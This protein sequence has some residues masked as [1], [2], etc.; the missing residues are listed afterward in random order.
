MKATIIKHYDHLYAVTQPVT[1][2]NI[3]IRPK[4]IV[5]T[6]SGSVVQAKPTGLPGLYAY[7][8]VDLG[9]IATTNPSLGLPLIKLD[10]T[11]EIPREVEIEPVRLFSHYSEDFVKTAVYKNSNIP[12]VNADGFVNITKAVYMNKL[13]EEQFRSSN[14]YNCWLNLDYSFYFEEIQEFLNRKGYELI[15]HTAVH[16]NVEHR[17]SIPYSGE[18]EKV[19]NFN[20]ERTY[21]LAIKPGVQPP[22]RFN[23]ETLNEFSVNSVFQREVRKNLLA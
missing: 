10:I 11:K 20:T 16:E 8:F 15:I 12:V 13:T 9:A 23:V 22:I 18:T 21:T 3:Y 6:G 1:D 2:Q 5:G 14:N 17:R 19:G 4:P 7:H